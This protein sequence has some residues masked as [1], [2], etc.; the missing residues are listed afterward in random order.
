[1]ATPEARPALRL[2]RARVLTSHGR[3]ALWALAAA[4]LC[5]LA[6]AASPAL[7]TTT[8]TV[9]TTADIAA[10]AGA[11]GNSSTT[12]PSP[13]SLR[14]ATCLANNIGGTV[15]ITVPAGHYNLANGEL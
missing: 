5:Q 2:T 1:M 9:S 13:L 8:L 14:E 15:N 12:V 3:R 6:L 10:N 11:C 7:A 4:V